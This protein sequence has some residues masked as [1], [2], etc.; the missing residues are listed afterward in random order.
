[1]QALESFLEDRSSSIVAV[2]V[3]A[4]SYALYN[5]IRGSVVAYRR[6]VYS[7]ENGCKPVPAYPHTDPIFGLD[8]FIEDSK[9][10]KSGGF[11]DRVRERYSDVGEGVHTYTHLT[12]GRRVITTAEPENIKTILATKFKDFE[13]PDSRKSALVPLLG[14][15]IFTTDGKEW[16][17]SRTLLRPSFNRSLIGDLQIFEKHVSKMIARIPKDKSTVDMQTLFFMLTMDSGKL[18]ACSSSSKYIHTNLL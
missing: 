17:T 7:K 6:F 18:D 10:L 13:L 14:H 5:I 11:I 9:L 15:G 12:L 16:E 4:G 8:L 3:L 2:A 1:M